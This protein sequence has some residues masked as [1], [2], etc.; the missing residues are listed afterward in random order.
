MPRQIHILFN[1]LALFVIT[2][3]AVDTFYRVVGIQLYRMG[4][5]KVVILSGPRKRPSPLLLK[6]R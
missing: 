2:Y 6:K 3:I 4:G 5:E 1:L